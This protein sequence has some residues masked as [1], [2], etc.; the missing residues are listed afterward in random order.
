M[1]E[2]STILLTNEN[3]QNQIKIDLNVLE[4]IL[5]IA[6]TKVEGVYE[7][8]GTLASNVNRIFGRNNQGKGVD[9][10]VVDGKLIVDVYAYFNNGVSVPTVALELQKKLRNQLMQMTDL[11]LDEVNV[12]VVGLYS[13]KED[14][15]VNPE[16]LFA[17]EEEA[18][19]VNEQQN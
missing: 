6:A 8:R 11:N 15:Q 16:T 4:V 13:P 18:G 3:D 10:K 1:A 19:E 7:M 14:D 17:D 2:T 12:H 9:L 5:G